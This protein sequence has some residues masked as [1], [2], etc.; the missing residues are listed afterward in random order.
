MT[1]YAHRRFRQHD[2]EDEL[3]PVSRQGGRESAA[4]FRSW[5][6][7]LAALRAGGLSRPLCRE[8]DDECA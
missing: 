7:R 4:G 8:Y 2:D 1:P 3:H 5:E 6:E